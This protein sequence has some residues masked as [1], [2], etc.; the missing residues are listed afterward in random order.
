[1]LSFFGDALV[2]GYA[3]SKGGVAPLTKS[4]ALAY[5]AKGIRVNAVAQAGSRRR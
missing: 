4:L 1:M 2:P 5:A 3:A